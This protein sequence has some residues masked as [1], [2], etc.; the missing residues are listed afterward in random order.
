MNMTKIEQFNTKKRKGTL[1]KISSPAKKNTSDAEFSDDT[2]PIEKEKGVNDRK[3]DKNEE[4]D[5]EKE[6]EFPDDTPP[7][8]MEEGVSERKDGKNEK[9][10]REK[11]QNAHMAL[12]LLVRRKV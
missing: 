11:R 7:V 10:M 8:D 3:Y 12:L 5:K 1:P 4:Y 9:L 6:A 2:S